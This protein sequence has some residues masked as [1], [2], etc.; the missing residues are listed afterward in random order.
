MDNSRVNLGTR[1]PDCLRVSVVSPLEEPFWRVV[2]RSAREIVE[3]VFFGERAAP[4][5]DQRR[6]QIRRH[7]QNILELDV[8]VEHGAILTVLDAVDDL[9]H[10]F[11]EK[12]NIK[13]NPKM[14]KMAKNGKK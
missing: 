5:I 14:A 6:L 3:F 8:A 11:P 2:L 9:E 1:L 4:E 7:D 10:D 13:K 12:S